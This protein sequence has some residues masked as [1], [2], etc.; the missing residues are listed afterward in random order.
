MDWRDEENE[1]ELKT[2]RRR[3]REMLKQTGKQWQN[4]G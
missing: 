4:V 1:E 2:K 3:E